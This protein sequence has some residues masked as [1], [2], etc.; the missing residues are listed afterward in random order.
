MPC[1]QTDN[2]IM[3]CMLF[4]KQNLFILIFN[5]NLELIDRKE[6]DIHVHISNSNLKCIHLQREIGVFNYFIDYDSILKIL[7][8]KNDGISYQLYDI[9]E[10]DNLININYD[11]LN[12]PNILSDLLK[13]SNT[14]FGIF[15]ADYNNNYLMIIL[16]DIYGNNNNNLIT[17]FYK[18]YY[19][20]YQFY[21]FLNLIAFMYGN[22]IGIGLNDVDEEIW[23]SFPK[24]IIF[25]YNNE[26]QESD[27]GIINNIINDNNLYYIIN[28]NDYFDIKINNN[29]FGYEFIGINV[30][31][32]INISSGINFYR[33]SDTNN[34]IQEND[35]L[36][37]EDT[38]TIDYS[39]INAKI[40]DDFY[41]ELSKLIGEPDYEIFNSYTDYMQTFGTENA[42]DFFEKQM[43]KVN[44]VKIKFNFACYQNCE[45]CEYVGVSSENQKCLSCK[46][47]DIKCYI[48][49][50]NNCD[51]I[52]SLKYKFY[53]DI[54]ILKCIFIDL[55]CPDNY[56]FENIITK[57]CKYNITFD[58]LISENYIYQI[59]QII[60]EKI[61]QL[62][63]DEIKNKNIDINKDIL[64]YSSNL[65]IHLTT[66]EKMES[67][68]NNE[69]YN[70]VST[71]DLN[72]CEDVL[73]REYGINGS[74]S[75]LKLDIK[76]KDTY[77]T[78]VEY[79]IINPENGEIL[80]ISKCENIKIDIYAPVNFSQDYLE[81]IKEMQEQGYDILNPE[82]PFYNDICTPYNS[83]NNTDVLLID[84][85]KDFYISNLSLCEENCEYK[86]FDVNTSKVKCECQKKTEVIAESSQRNFSPMVLLENFYSFKKYTNYKVLKCFRLA[87]DFNRLK[88]N[89]GNYVIL[90]IILSF[91]VLMIIIFFTQTKKY[92]NLLD[93]IIELNLNVDKIIIKKS[94]K[95]IFKVYEE[96]IQNEDNNNKNAINK[97][98][99]KT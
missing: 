90:F 50:E 4:N 11:D 44:T 57:E 81:F 83:E 45:T 16:C 5:E 15:Y 59:N 63:D 55:S 60:L 24:V 31:K 67:S 9:F 51:N 98:E 14:R 29:L 74:L 42:E 37:I 48:E 38:I 1:F 56:P 7:E 36:N 71:I 96:E 66:V 52:D 20:L 94:E 88:K 93:K 70:N 47:N 53:N 27:I 46:D 41:I 12:P 28:I 40:D 89:I 84:R 3:E 95:N 10:N 18:I 99:S 13:I 26:T 72:E 19:Q 91:I 78:Q 69:L 65:S 73:K 76:R 75:I 61:I 58:E 92:N 23:F 82:D 8:L 79:I 43:Y 32:L 30:D 2:N 17:R 6:I 22:H 86:Y 64:I 25:G 80:N 77:S 97:K 87:F 35:I 68:L 62:F 21:N 54:G 39:N 34:L 49:S 85:K 33:N